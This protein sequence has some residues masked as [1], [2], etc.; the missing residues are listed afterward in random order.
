MSKVKS[1]REARKKRQ[2]RLRKKVLGTSECPRLSVFKSLKHLYVQLIDDDTGQTLMSASTI[3]KEYTG[4]FKD[5][6]CNIKT[7]KNLGS[8]FVEKA[9]TGK[10]QKLRFDRSGYKYHGVIKA[11]ADSI[12]EGGITF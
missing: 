1:R 7:A 4:K 8:L 10:V 9:K 11:L 3:S 2:I 12:R 6:G 5:A